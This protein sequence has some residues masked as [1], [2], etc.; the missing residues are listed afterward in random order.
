MR[1][2]PLLA[3]ALALASTTVEAQR[4]DA[5]AQIDSPR[6]HLY[7]TEYARSEGVPARRLIRGAD[8]TERVDM[9]W[10]FFVAVGRGR[11]VLIDC[12]TDAFV[13]PRAEARR[14]AWSVVDAVGVVDALDRLGLEPSRVT[15]VVLTHHHWDHV[16]GLP[17]FGSATVHAHRAE[18]SRVPER[19][20]RPVERSSRLRA[21]TGSPY[22]VAD[23]LAVREAG[24]HT[25]H[26]LMVDVECADGAIAIAGD[27]A[28][29][30]RN[31]ERRE[32]VAVT[33]SASRNVAD[34]Q[35]AAHDVGRD[36]VLPGHD[37]ALFERHPSPIDGVAVICR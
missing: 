23:D 31:V 12:G 11:V 28:Y 32:A 4:V 14:R 36:R 24:R 35:A 34:V 5:S 30:Y 9:S 26:Q 17:R 22:E 18:W 15:D 6:W 1:S 16:G 2:A 37:P 10:Y 8:P 7:A 19:L 29:L 25:A 33:S 21:V 13:G 20:R 27:A 3:L